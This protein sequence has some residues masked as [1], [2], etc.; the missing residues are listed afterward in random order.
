MAM[1][2]ILIFVAV[3]LLWL[4]VPWAMSLGIPASELDYWARR[5]QWGDMF[6]AVNAL[7]SGLAFAGLI[8]AIRLQ[9]QELG[10]Q[11][12]ELALQR[13]EMAAS[14]TELAKQVAAQEALFR[15]FAA[16]VAVAAANA[17]IQAI[18]WDSYEVNATTSARTKYAKPVREIANR[19]NA[20]H[21][22]LLKPSAPPAQL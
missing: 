21:N 18:H 22:D 11:R 10:L 15:A 2:S 1:R 14:R 4:S 20:M 17:E 19:L 12:K 9:S 13:S 8:W 16:Q 3:V 5:G 6:G 7:F